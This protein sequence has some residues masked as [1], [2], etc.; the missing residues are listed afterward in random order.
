M[1]DKSRQGLNKL[2]EEHSEAIVVLIL[3]QELKAQHTEATVS[4]MLVVT[5]N[6]GPW[7]VITLHEDGEFVEFAMWNITGNVYEVD[8][9]G[10]AADDP[11]ITIT[12]F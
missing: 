9:H 3:H 10:A 6:P 11:C 7:T 2:L 4:Q 1:E 12:E 5:D 8:E